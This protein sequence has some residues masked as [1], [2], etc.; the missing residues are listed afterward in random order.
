MAAPFYLEAPKGDEYRPSFSERLSNGINNM[1]SESFYNLASALATPGPWAQRL[2]AGLAGFGSPIAEQKKK[3]GLA[4]AFDQLLPTIP[5]AQRP[6]FQQMVQNDPQ[7]LAGAVSAQMFAK[8]PEEPSAIREYKFSQSQ[9]YK[10]TFDDWVKDQKRAGASNTTVNVGGEKAFDRGAG[11][12]Q[13]GAYGKIAEEGLNARGQLS[14]INTLGESLAKTPGGWKTGLQNVALQ[15]GIPIGKNADDVTLA[16]SIIAKLVPTQRAP[17]TG[18]M[19]DADLA[20]FKDSLPKL[21]NTAGGNQLIINTMKSMAQFKL[22]QGRIAAAALNGQITR[23]QALEALMA[24]P[25][26]ME[27]FK[28]RAAGGEVKAPARTKGVFNPATGTVE[29]K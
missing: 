7:A 27:Q 4:S 10:G 16:N 18:Q 25:D 9:G 5:E 2:T 28:A 19:S 22:D 29:F 12:W 8:P 3:Q 13:A 17:G 21:I 26:P 1:P 23:Q 11:E 6:I 14:Q 24:L 20:L 15:W